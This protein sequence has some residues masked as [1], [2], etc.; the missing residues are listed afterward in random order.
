MKELQE[1]ILKEGR[2][3]P[4]SILKVDSFLNHQIDMELMDHIG[5]YFYE[6]FKESSVMRTVMRVVKPVCI[7]ILAVVLFSLGKETFFPGGI[8]MPFSVLISACMFVTLLR[9][10]WSVP[11]VIGTSALLGILFYGVLPLLGV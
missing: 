4:G 1:R 8:F 9:Y 5:A 6:K 10:K 3:L 7:A 11:K 2:I